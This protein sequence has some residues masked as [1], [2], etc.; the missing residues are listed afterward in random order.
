M[1]KNRRPKTTVYLSTSSSSSGGLEMNCTLWLFSGIFYI[2]AHPI[3]RQQL[4][5]IVETKREASNTQ[6]LNASSSNTPASVTFSILQKCKQ[7]A[8]LKLSFCRRERYPQ[9]IVHRPPPKM[10]S[11][12]GRRVRGNCTTVVGGIHSHGSPKVAPA[13]ERRGNT[14]IGDPTG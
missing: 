5:K 10:H 1:K 11:R 9:P 8:L 12:K 14:G 7:Q 2:A 13:V 3:D 6:P 4:I